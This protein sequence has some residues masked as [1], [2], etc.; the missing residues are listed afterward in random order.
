MNLLNYPFS[1]V[2][3]S[4][5]LI[6]GRE[7]LPNAATAYATLTDASVTRT[8]STHL[9]VFAGA[10]ASAPQYV[11]F[12]NSISVG[13]TAAVTLTIS[14]GT[15]TGK[16]VIG[17]RLKDDGTT[18]LYIEDSSK[19]VFTGQGA[20]YP[21]PGPEPRSPKVKLWTWT[22]TSGAFDSTG[23]TQAQ[24]NTDCWVDLIEVTNK[25]GSAATITITEGASTPV[26]F[27]TSVSIP[28]NSTSS[29]VDPGGAFYRGG[30]VM[31]A[32]TASALNVHFRLRKKRVNGQLA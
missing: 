16:V 13:F 32:G 8:D 10:S 25:S 7:L 2:D 3:P 31:S 15:G 23:G 12:N 14:S 27:L 30:L 29:V 20:S 26:D 1:N 21:K 6:E 19:N 17:V 11:R 18:E 22:I 5:T 4:A 24:V 9:S 28:A